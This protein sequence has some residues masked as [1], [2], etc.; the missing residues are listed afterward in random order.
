MAKKYNIGEFVKVKTS[1]ID[2]K[3]KIVPSDYSGDFK[4]KS[5]E[6]IYKYKHYQDMP[7]YYTLHVD[8]DM[9]GWTIGS[10]HLL[11]QEIDKKFLNCRFYEV[12]E[13]YFI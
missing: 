6:I 1:I 13:G 12:S 11:H 3:E 8:N 4:I 5:F 7:F 2:G 10:W 9:L